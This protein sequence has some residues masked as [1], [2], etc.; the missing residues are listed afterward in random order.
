MMLVTTCAGGYRSTTLRG[1]EVGENAL[2]LLLH[3][4]SLAGFE[5]K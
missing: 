2:F 5:K 4:N 3:R 1:L